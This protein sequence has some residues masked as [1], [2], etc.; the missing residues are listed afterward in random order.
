[1]KMKEFRWLFLAVLA[2]ILFVGFVSE[3]F[4]LGMSMQRSN[5][6]YAFTAGTHPASLALSL[7]ISGLYFLLMYASSPNA[8]KPLSGVFRRFVAFLLDFYLAMM[9]ISPVVGLL[10]IITEWKRSGSFQWNFE[11]TTPAPADTW[12]LWAGFVFSVSA[13]SFYYAFPIV[14]RRPSP[15]ACITGYQILPDDGVTINART[16]LLR[17]LLGFIAA[18]SAY[19]A[20]FVARDRKKGKFWLDRVFGTR[21]VTLR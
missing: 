2:V 4:D 16:A 13:L 7:I 9:A 10:P 21:A 11:R 17:T 20:P 6:S 8:G 1:M 15:G 19:L 12:L 18:S 14:R 3:P 5:G